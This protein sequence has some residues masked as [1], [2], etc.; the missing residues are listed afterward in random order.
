MPFNIF[1][2]FCDFGLLLSKIQN[3]GIY[4]CQSLLLDHLIDCGG[5]YTVMF[6]T[7]TTVFRQSGELFHQRLEI[8]PSFIPEVLFWWCNYTG[9]LHQCR[10]RCS[11][12]FMVHITPYA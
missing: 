12:S 11:T 1:W 5:P 6:I 9:S 4:V 10:C 2:V 8:L 3:M 7:H